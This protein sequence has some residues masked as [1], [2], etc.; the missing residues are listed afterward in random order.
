[1]WDLPGK[2][3]F[4]TGS[5]DFLDPPLVHSLFRTVARPCGWADLRYCPEILLERVYRNIIGWH[6]TRLGG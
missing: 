5:L 3:C 1:M 2:S 4:V 6:R